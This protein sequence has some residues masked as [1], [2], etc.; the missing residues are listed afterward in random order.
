MLI[1]KAHKVAERIEHP[2]RRDA[3]EAHDI[4]RLLRAVDT[5]KLIADLQSLAEDPVAGVTM[6]VGI[7]YLRTLFATGEDARGSRLAG[8]AE[9]IVGD[10][11]Q[12]ALSVSFLAQDLISGLNVDGS[13]KLTARGA[14]C[15][16]FFAHRPT[17]TVRFAAGTDACVVE[18]E[19]Y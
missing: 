7:E 4:Y 19:V 16:P 9:E 2:K 3:K 13:V 12:V 14:S 10:P 8:Q 17:C 11:A 18:D 6:R 5:E 1:A 15:S